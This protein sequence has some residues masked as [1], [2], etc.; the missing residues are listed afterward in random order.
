MG[1]EAGIAAITGFVQLA[2]SGA[3]NDIFGVPYVSGQRMAGKQVHRA[4]AI[5]A[6]YGFYP[7]EIFDFGLRT[8]AMEA[9]CFIWKSYFPLQRLPEIFGRRAIGRQI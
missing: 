3:D 4:A 9:F 2:A 1:A 8:A 7:E 5:P 6:I